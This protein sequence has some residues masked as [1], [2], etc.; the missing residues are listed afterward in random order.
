V[1]R[2]NADGITYVGAQDFGVDGLGDEAIGIRYALKSSGDTEYL[3]ACCRF[4]GRPADRRGGV[5]DTGRERHAVDNATPSW[6]PRG[7]A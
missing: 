2:T 6:C 4:P 1:G 3:G 7:E 5:S